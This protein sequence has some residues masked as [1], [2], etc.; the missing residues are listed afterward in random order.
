MA[1]GSWVSPMQLA[2]LPLKLPDGSIGTTTIE[3]KTN[4]FR[5]VREGYVETISA[6]LHLGKTTIVVD[7]H[8]RDA[9][10][11]LVARVT[12]TQAVSALDEPTVGEVLGR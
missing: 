12:Q 5:T 8:L 3:S 6:P 11:R 1:V 7:T 4:F 10:G 9:D 2:G